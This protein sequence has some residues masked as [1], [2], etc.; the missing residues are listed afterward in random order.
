[1]ESNY[2][3]VIVLFMF[4]TSLQ[5][6]ANDTKVYTH[7]YLLAAAAAIPFSPV[8]TKWSQK[9]MLQKKTMSFW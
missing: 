8:E 6:E 9:T 4:Q 3:T 1:M 2:C 5:T 7:R